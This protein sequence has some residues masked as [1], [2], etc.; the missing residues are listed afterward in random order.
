MPEATALIE[1]LED[2]VGEKDMSHIFL[3]FM[4]LTDYQCL[5]SELSRCIGFLGWDRNPS[6][7]VES[8]TNLQD[9]R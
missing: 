2:L 6:P 7:I 8:S 1:L 5:L 3:I 4:Q 9:H